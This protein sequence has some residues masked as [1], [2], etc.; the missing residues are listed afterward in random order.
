MRRTEAKRVR[1][2]E[3]DQKCQGSEFLILVGLEKTRVSIYYT[4]DRTPI[5]Q[6]GGRRPGRRGNHFYRCFLHGER[7]GKNC[8][9]QASLRLFTPRR[10]RNLPPFHR[11]I[12]TDE[13]P[14]PPDSIVPLPRR[15][16]DATT[17]RECSSKNTRI[18]VCG[19]QR[20]R[21]RPGAS[22]RR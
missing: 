15:S 16:L 7:A 20:G 17:S 8:H 1:E 3:R 2:R 11:V 9:G 12:V 10:Q 5:W 22:G 18:R 14:S 19:Q 13:R 6:T 21:R 4:R